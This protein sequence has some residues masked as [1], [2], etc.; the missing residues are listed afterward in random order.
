MLVTQ[1]CLDCFR[2]P[3]LLLAKEGVGLQAT[4]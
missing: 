3:S 4:E 1:V 2:P